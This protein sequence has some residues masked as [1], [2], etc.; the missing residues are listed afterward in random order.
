MNCGGDTFE[1]AIIELA[2]LVKDN[3]TDDGKKIIK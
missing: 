1:E 2:R 3:Y